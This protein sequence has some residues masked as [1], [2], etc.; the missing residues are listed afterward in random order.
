MLTNTTL[1]VNKIDYSKTTLVEQGLPTI[2]KGQVLLKVSEFSLTANNVTYAAMGDF[3]KYWEFFPAAEGDGIIPVWG[4]AQVIASDCDGIAIG[5]KFYGYYPMAT[6][7]LVEPTQVSASSFVDGVAHRQPLSIIYNQYI[8]CSHD[9]LYQAET[10]ALQML[11][12]PLFTTSFLLD[13]FFADNQFFGSEQLVLTS[14]SSKTALGMAFLL[15]HNR[16]SRPENYQII[17]LTSESNRAFVEDLGCYD[18]V[19]S[20]DEIETLDAGIK[21]SVVDF[22]GNGQVLGRLH[23]HFSTMLQ[24][25]CLVGASHWDQRAGM[26]ADLAGPQPIMFFA[27]S[28]AEKRLKNWGG[29]QFQQNLAAVWGLFTEFVDGW[30][31]VERHTGT[32]ATNEVYQQLLSGSFNPKVGYIVSLSD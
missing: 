8:R 5:E 12:R 22:A 32:E 29:A 28:Q 1:T 3:L 19:L 30:I 10:E 18:R 14:A 31:D 24:Y 7:L 9:P 23:Q 21:T 25:S 6:H 20:Y 11:L 26:P 2:G 4:F 17:G 15:N 13:D 16:T 27:P